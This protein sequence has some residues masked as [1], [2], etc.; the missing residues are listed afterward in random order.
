METNKNNSAKAVGRTPR[1]LL[2]LPEDLRHDLE[3]SAFAHDRNLT[4]EITRRLRESYALEKSG[5]KPLPDSYT[6]PPAPALVANDN[7]PANAIN[8][9]DQAMLQIFRAMSPEKQL[10]LLS[11]FK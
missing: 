4:A 11:L 9:T 1:F 6:A 10:A 7:G 3:R 8:G 2:N 5:V